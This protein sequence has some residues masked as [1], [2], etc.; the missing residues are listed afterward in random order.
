VGEEACYP[1]LT[2]VGSQEVTAA[3]YQAVMATFLLEG[4]IAFAG[5]KSLAQFLE[6][7]VVFLLVG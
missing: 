4:T 2:D 5:G 7:L 6:G 3:H 1:A